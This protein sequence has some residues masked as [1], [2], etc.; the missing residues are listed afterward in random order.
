MKNKYLVLSSLDTQIPK[1]F[2][3][4]LIGKW[5][6]YYNNKQVFNKLDIIIND[7]HWD[8]EKKHHHDYQYLKALHLKILKEMAK[9]LNTF[10]N[11]D[12]SLKYWRMLIDPFLIT[13]VGVI[14]DRWENLKLAFK[15]NKNIYI[16]NISN[17]NYISPAFDHI[18]FEKNI[19]SELWNHKILIKIINFAFKDKCKFLNNKLKLKTEKSKF[20]YSFFS[21]LNTKIKSLIFDFFTIFPKNHSVT[22]LDTNFN[23]KYRIKFF[24]ISNKINFFLGNKLEIINNNLQHKKKNEVVREKFKKNFKFKTK[25]KFETFL[26]S[27]LF[28]LIPTCLLEEYKSIF[29]IV[30]KLELKSKVIISQ[31]A[32]W[33]NP[34]KKN[35]IALNCEKGSKFYQL[36]HGGSIP[37]KEHNL[38]FYPNVSNKLITWYKSTKKNH[39]HLPSTIIFNSNFHNMK[40]IP[41]RNKNLTIIIGVEKRWQGKLYYGPHSA[42]ILD[43]YDHT[44]RFH[45]KIK[46]NIKKN[47]VLKL[48]AIDFGWDYKKI[49]KNIY[50]TG[51]IV[52]KGKISRVLENSKINIC[53]YPETTFSECMLTEIPT[54]LLY[55]KNLYKL[56]KDF[57]N[58]VSELL[59]YK[60]IFFNEIA[61]ADHINRVW[62]NPNAWWLQNGVQSVRKKFLNLCLKYKSDETDSFN[63]WKNYIKKI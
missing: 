56:N 3:A 36:Q 27:N 15:S 59:K 17:K 24:M 28:E 40:N 35:W 13:Y 54:I 50:T 39:V 4:V 7:F 38:N 57:N 51:K 37:K 42:Q 25:N 62:D 41:S 26:I 48:S 49:F 32:I 55:T 43:S 47:C 46:K 9:S 34:I 11:E 30:S 22:F 16:K 63:M 1:N 18:Q 19:H 44:L 29:D 53:T 33:G 58:L 60:I 14:F 8:N 23:L 61:A 5:C 6:K 12:H 31:Y 21:S 20:K 45:Q 52:D 10:H 2:D